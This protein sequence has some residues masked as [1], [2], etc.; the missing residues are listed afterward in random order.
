MSSKMESTQI[1]IEINKRVSNKIK[2]LTQISVRIKTD[3]IL[4]IKSKTQFSESK[5]RPQFSE[6]PGDDSQNMND[7]DQANNDAN[8]KHGENGNKIPTHK[9]NSKTP[10][11][12]IEILV[13]IRKT[14]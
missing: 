1:M 3:P 12:K 5:T 10:I 8:G 6:Y 9:I 2:I 7:S 11:L 13:M 4:R 14:R